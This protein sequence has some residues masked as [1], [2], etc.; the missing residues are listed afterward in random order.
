[1]Q[2]DL[3]RLVRPLRGYWSLN[4]AINLVLLLVLVVAGALRIGSSH[5]ATARIGSSRPATAR[6]G[7]SHPTTVITG[8]LHVEGT[9]LVDVNGNAVMLKGV[10]RVGLEYGCSGDGHYEVSDFRAMRSWGMNIVR[11]PLA[12]AFWQNRDGM[13]PGYRT[14]VAQVVANAEAAGMFVILDLH[15]VD[16]F[17]Q[18]DSPTQSN[19]IINPIYPMPP[20]SALSFWSQVASAYANDEHV[21]FELY[22]EPHNVSWSTWRDGGSVTLPNG[23]SYYTPGM[24][25]L[26]TEVNKT[27]PD[28]II[29]VGGIDWGYDLSGV[30]D[31]YAI[32][33]R[34]LVY[35]T[36]PYLVANGQP[37][38]QNSNSVDLVREPSD[39]HRAFGA[40]AQ[41]Y[42][43][44]STEFGQSDGGSGYDVQVMQYFTGLQTG[45]LAWSWKAGSEQLGELLAS[46]N[47]APSRFG[48]P[49]RAYM[50]GS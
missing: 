7:S 6:I 2:R 17:P 39:W 36:H 5:P 10:S 35:N 20:D 3:L 13:C 40:V 26:A 4:V 30:L 43:V 44:I 8:G 32:T 48:A 42:P 1:M 12:L 14:T 49:I 25:L 33:A 15:S 50:L 41:R 27:A 37:V 23:T 47:G 21:L 16:P 22:N 34:N 18:D 29:I 38:G 9:H 45:Y 28:R 24:Q 46:Y 19:N 31:G 11:I